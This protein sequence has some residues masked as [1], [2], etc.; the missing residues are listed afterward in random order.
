MEYKNIFEF[1]DTIQDK[2]KRRT[3]VAKKSFYFTMKLLIS[4]IAIF[5][6]TIEKLSFHLSRVRILVSMECKKNRNDFFQEKP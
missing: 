6:S 2:E 1:C 4:F 5:I 3:F